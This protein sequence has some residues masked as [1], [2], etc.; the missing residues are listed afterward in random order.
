[1]NGKFEFLPGLDDAVVLYDSRG[2][3]CLVITQADPPAQLVEE[4]A[5]EYPDCPVHDAVAAL[6][7]T[8]EM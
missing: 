4:W 2:E 3:P 6:R 8:K 1:M 5:S 7:E